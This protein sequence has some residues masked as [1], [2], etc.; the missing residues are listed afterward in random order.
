MGL[1]VEGRIPGAGPG[2][3]GVLIAGCA[4]AMHECGAMAGSQQITWEVPA[5]ISSHLLFQSCFGWGIY[6]LSR[7]DLQGK[8]FIFS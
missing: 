5:F 1:R 7:P 4:E 3:P 6:T 8:D 2:P